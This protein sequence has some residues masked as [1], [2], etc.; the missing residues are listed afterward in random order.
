MKSIIAKRY[1]MNPDKIVI[2]ENGFDDTIFD[3]KKDVKYQKK[4]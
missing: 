4:R 2:V 3:T 1:A